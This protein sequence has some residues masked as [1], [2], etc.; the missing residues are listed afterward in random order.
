MIKMA[1]GSDSD[2][3]AFLSQNNVSSEV[4]RVSCGKPHCTSCGEPT[5][6]HFGPYGPNKCIFGTVCKLVTRVDELEARCAKK[7]EELR[8]LDKIST[9]RQEALLATIDALEERLQDLESRWNDV[10]VSLPSR[11]QSSCAVKRSGLEPDDDTNFSACSGVESTE[12]EGTAECNSLNNHLTTTS[13]PSREDE[14]ESGKKL[15]EVEQQKNNTIHRTLSPNDNASSQR[16]VQEPARTHKQTADSKSP[17]TEGLGAKK[18]SV[19]PQRGSKHNSV[20]DMRDVNASGTPD[21]CVDDGWQLV[22]RRSRRPGAS[23]E[24]LR[25]RGGRSHLK[26]YGSDRVATTTFHLSR[27]G[28][29]CTPADVLRYCKT[30]GVVLTGCVFIRTRVWGTQSAKIFVAEKCASEVVT[31][32]F[33]PDLI[34]C[35]RW[36]FTPPRGKLRQS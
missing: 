18:H 25:T 10:H 22:Q 31:A 4:N 19:I 15:E 26:L 8:Q 28:L 29:D 20:D 1:D 23:T 33:W 11:H 36:E 27:I 7:E 5:K 9:A 6:G 35:R 14:K 12:H 13:M 2:A 30:R 34:K 17:A 24:T 32:D 3:P 16:T 21:S